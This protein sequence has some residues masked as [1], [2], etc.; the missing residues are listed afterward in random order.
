MVRIVKHE[1]FFYING[2]IF[3]AFVKITY[4]YKHRKHVRRITHPAIHTHTHL[5]FGFDFQ[6]LKLHVLEDLPLRLESLDDEAALGV[7][8]FP[9][10]GVDDRLHLIRHQ[11]ELLFDAGDLTLLR[12]QMLRLNL[13]NAKGREG[14]RMLGRNRKE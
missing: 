4:I 10:P 14:R 2:S 3:I 12:Q 7:E 1:L 5:V 13:R 9:F 11:D 8:L 6:L